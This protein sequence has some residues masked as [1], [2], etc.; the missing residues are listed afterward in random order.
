MLRDFEVNAVGPAR[1][2][3]ALWRGGLLGDGQGRR[4][5]LITSSMGSIANLERESLPAISYGMSKAAANWWAKKVSIE[6]KDKGLLVGIIHPGWVKTRMG[7]TLA[8]A[9]G[10]PEPPLTLEQ[11]VTGVL[12]Q[13]DNLSPETSGKYLTWDGQQLPW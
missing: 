5:V 8:D 7:Q 3:Q 4:F 13:I 1:L 6:F 9:I 2:L 12:E 11:S 10:F